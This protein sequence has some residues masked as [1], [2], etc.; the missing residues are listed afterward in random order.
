M[1]EQSHG[2][3]LAAR[4]VP[5]EETPRFKAVMYTFRCV[6]SRN[7]G[8]RQPAGGRHAHPP[9]PRAAS[10]V[11]RC[12]TSRGAALRPL[13]SNLSNNRRGKLLVICI[14]TA[15]YSGKSV[16]MTSNSPPFASGHLIKR[17]GRLG[18]VRQ[19]GVVA[20]GRHLAQKRAIARAVGHRQPSALLS[21]AAK[22]LVPAHRHVCTCQRAESRSACVHVPTCGDGAG[23]RHALPHPTVRACSEAGAYSIRP[24][25]GASACSRAQ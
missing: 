16:Q 21:N 22:R 18:A 7:R 10:L 12:K 14:L 1:R 24:C 11:R 9:S 2:P 15:G 23:A 20:F 8:W 25:T 3:P 4:G 13:A 17:D 6:L 5:R 19:L